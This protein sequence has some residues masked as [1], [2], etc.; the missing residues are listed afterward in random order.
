MKLRLLPVLPLKKTSEEA[1]G[2]R[3]G[4]RSGLEDKVADQLRGLGQ[5]VHYE[6]VAIKYT[7]PLKEKRYT[8][9]FIL[10]NGIVIETKGRLVTA[11]R[12]KHRSI[13]NEHPSLDIRFVFSRSKQRI[14]KTSPTTYATWC[15]KYGFPFA[16][17]LIPLAWIKEAPQASRIVALEQAT[18]RSFKQLL[19]GN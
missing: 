3:E 4:Y 2:V 10:P 1:R 7:P 16:D 9:D 18:G 11:D 14:S 13:S 8:P 5:P 19:K 6:V 12:M 17:R 15:E